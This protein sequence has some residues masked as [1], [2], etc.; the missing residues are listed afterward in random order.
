[1]HAVSIDLSTLPA[2][3]HEAARAISSNLLILQ[4]IARDFRNAA[5]FYAHIRTLVRQN[6]IDAQRKM[7]WTKMAGRSGAIDAN[8]FRAVMEAINKAKAPTIWD[9]VNMVERDAAVRMFSSEFQTIGGIRTSTA[10]P[11]ELTKDEN[12]RN[13][14][15]A[16]AD[17]RTSS[18][19]FR[20][21]TFISDLMEASDDH[22]VFSATFKGSLVSYE[23]S[24]A[25][26]DALDRIAA[27][28][29][30]A[31]RPLGGL[32]QP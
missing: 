3:E 18:S 9:K 31:F 20:A 14:H 16:K 17:V 21:G 23:L 4:F 15:A 19:D 25:K 13:K 8:G 5:D 10:H 29:V 2:E 12:Q 22:L 6:G 1:M 30:S 11:G 28:Y 32:Q 7:A 24:L 27:R 26:A